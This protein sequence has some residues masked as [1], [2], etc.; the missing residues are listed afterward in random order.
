M[1]DDEI[2]NFFHELFSI[3]VLRDDYMTG[4]KVVEEKPLSVFTYIMPIGNVFFDKNN[5]PQKTIIHIP[6]GRF[7]TKASKA[8]TIDYLNYRF[9]EQDNHSEQPDAQLYDNQ[10]AYDEMASD[11]NKYDLYTMFINYMREAQKN[12]QFANE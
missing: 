6:Q 9:D 10:K 4:N 7:A 12:M 1:T 8:S 5:K 11:Q 2:R 3:K